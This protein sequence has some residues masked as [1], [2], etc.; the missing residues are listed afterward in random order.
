MIHLNFWRGYKV[1]E[2]CN[3]CNEVEDDSFHIINK[4]SILMEVM[5]TFQLHDKYNNNL[6]ISFGLDNDHITNFIFFHI[7]TVVFRSQFQSFSSKDLCSIILIRK[8]KNRIKKICK[9]VFIITN[10]RTM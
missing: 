5:G 1:G 9:S 6:T 7:K 2:R 8:C 4:C 3:L 10:L